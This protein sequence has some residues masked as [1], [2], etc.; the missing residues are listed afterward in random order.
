LEAEG[1]AEVDYNRASGQELG[2]EVHVDFRRSCQQDGFQAFGFNDFGARRST[3][4]TGFAYEFCIGA[5]IGAVFQQD[6][7]AMG[8][9]REDANGFDTAV[10]SESDDSDGEWHGDGYLFSGLYKYTNTR[11]VVGQF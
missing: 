3:A 5:R 2:G 1:P 7:F 6:R 11:P 4:Y 10:A 8:V 9:T